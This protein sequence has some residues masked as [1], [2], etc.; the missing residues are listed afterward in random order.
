MPTDS[1]AFCKVANKSIFVLHNTTYFRVA[2]KNPLL[3][4]C[5]LRLYKSTLKFKG[6]VHV[7][8]LKKKFFFFISFVYILFFTNHSYFLLEEFFLFLIKN[9]QE[10]QNLLGTKFL[11]IFIF[12]GKI[13]FYQFFLL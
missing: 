11:L 3:P 10:R 7:S 1:V 9:N 6:A 13:F 2:H 5:F 8:F 12:V 4:S